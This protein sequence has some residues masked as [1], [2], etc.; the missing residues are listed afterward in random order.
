MHRIME[1]PDSSDLAKLYTFAVWMLGDRE[2][3]AERA[4]EVMRAAPDLGFV[5][6]VQEL[7]T[8]LTGPGTRKGLRAE[9]Q[10]F[11]AALD[12]L[13]RTELTVSPGDHPTIQRDPRRLRVLQWEL[14]RSCLS[15][16]MQGVAPGPRATFI[17][18]KILGFSAA[19]L[20]SLFG[21]TT[22]SVTVSLGRA[23]R[24]LDNYLGAR[25]QHL[26]RGNSCRCETRLGVALAHGFIGWPGHPEELPDAP[27]FATTHSDV[28][29]LYGSLPGFIAPTGT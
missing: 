17:L 28:G 2:A 13:L 19:E 11:L 22:G 10:S 9:R 15:A 7:L 26:A 16:V 27:V 3:G 21:V 4:A 29:A 24:S 5:G 25:C 6:W 12:E 23:E 18:I 1:T 8:P 20:T 14:K